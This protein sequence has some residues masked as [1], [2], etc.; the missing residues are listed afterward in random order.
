MREEIFRMERVTYIE[1]EV[2]MLSDFHLQIYRGEI[3]GMVPVTNHGLTAF[4]KLLQNNLPIFDGYVY[5]CGEKVNSWKRSYRPA[6]RISIIQAKSSLVDRLTVT[7]NIFVIRQGFRQELVRTGLL[8]RQLQP[9]LEDIGMDIPVDSYVEELPVFQRVVVELLRAVIMGHRLIV[10][11]EIGG[12]IS[13]E[14]LAK[15]HRI[16]RHYAEQGFSFLYICSHL[17]EIS[18]ICGRA[19]Q[20][21]N[22]RIQKIITGENMEEEVL[23]ICPDEYR[24]MVLRHLKNKPQADVGEEILRWRQ[25]D[26]DG[27]VIFDFR[28]YRGECLALQIA[29]NNG[30]QILTEALTGKREHSGGQVT[31]DGE[32]LPLTGDCRIGVVQEF[33]TKTM[34][35]RG[36]TYMENLCMALAQR[37]PGLWMNQKIR[38]SIRREYGSMLGDEV[39]FMQ[40][41]ELS[42]KQKYQLI[43]TRIL[44]QKP[45]VVFCIHP[46][47][48]ADVDHRMFIWRMLEML[49]KEGIAVVIVSVSLSDSLALADRLLILEGGGRVQE[50][51]R[52][53]FETIS[54]KV[55][56]T[57]PYKS[58][59]ENMA[60]KEMGETRP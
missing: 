44:L 46:F 25:K 19:A 60:N 21:S 56:W 12:L 30:F 23:R 27:Q 22:G 5:Y 50:I 9:F 26:G 42:E 8:K 18:G 15:L 49:Q 54:A 24:S 11:N 20:F 14:E 40:V 37:M 2:V 53:K 43:Y 57:H 7:D 13:Y 47:K 4:L 10:L 36:M 51:P 1:N 39:F 45:R 31:M 6:N 52:E 16:L 58:R 48:G 17:E 34:I 32:E 41:E 3:M 28:V 33:A 29:E 59:E 38:N 35:F 55:P